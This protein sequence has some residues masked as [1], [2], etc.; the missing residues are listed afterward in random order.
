VYEN[1]P[2]HQFSVL[3]EAE[4]PDFMRRDMLAWLVGRR[5]FKKLQ[6][7]Q[8]GLNDYYYNCVFT[9]V[10]IIYI[11]GHCHG[12]RLTAN[13]DSPYAHGRAT[14][15]SLSAGEHRV[16]LENRS[17]IIDSYTYPVVQFTGG[18]IDIVNITDDEQRHFTF[19]GLSSTEIVTVDNET[20][21]ISSTMGGEK[22]SNFTSKK[23][24]RLR[25]GYNTLAVVA[26]GDATITCPHYAMVGF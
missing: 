15:I 26:K 25:R 16:K 18:G 17:D 4:I 21:H 13:F 9:D 11:N 12:F 8:T 23:W 3:S 1:A 22:L 19:S 24:L 2:Q 6:I 14:T 10:E 7:H 5:E 20:K